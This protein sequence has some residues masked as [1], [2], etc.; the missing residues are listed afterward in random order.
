MALAEVILSDAVATQCFLHAL[1][2][3]HEEIIGV[4]LGEVV[5]ADGATNL[6]NYRTASTEVLK[7]ARVWGSFAVPRSDKRADRVEIDANVLCFAADKA[8]AE[9]LRTG[10]RTRVIG[11]YH[12]HPHITPYPSHVDLNCQGTYQWME[13]GWVGLI[14]SVFHFD[15]VNSGRCSIHCFQSSNVAS[16]GWNH[17]KVPLRIACGSQLVPFDHSPFDQAQRIAELLLQENRAALDVAGDSAPTDRSERTETQL[18]CAGGAP[19]SQRF[20]KSL[21]AAVYAQQAFKIMHTITIPLTTVI[22]DGMLQYADDL[23]ATERAVLDAAKARESAL[24]ARL[25][26][27]HME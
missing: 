17:E 20:Y 16:G 7:V 21:I 25:L 27:A 1:T 14:F 11:W 13:S 23:L 8:E 5:A 10:R 4:L 15:R 3:E 24:R 2:T 9:T 18:R 26:D 6:A 19:E 12:S 22:H